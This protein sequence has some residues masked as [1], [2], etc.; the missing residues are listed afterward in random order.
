MRKEWAHGLHSSPRNMSM[1]DEF[2]VFLV[3]LTPFVA[4][5]SQWWS[6]FSYLTVELVSRLYVFTLVWKISGRWLFFKVYQGK[7]CLKFVIK[8]LSYALEKMNKPQTYVSSHL[9]AHSDLYLN[10]GHCLH[11]FCAQVLHPQNGS[12]CTDLISPNIIVNINNCSWN[13]LQR[14][15]FFRNGNRGGWEKT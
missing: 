9:S 14:L 2:A 1:Y 3:N 11:F 4:W 8:Y 12:N 5:C 6:M 7:V 15:G 10:Y 13:L